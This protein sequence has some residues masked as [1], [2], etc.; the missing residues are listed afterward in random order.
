MDYGELVSI[1]YSQH[2]IIV[3]AYNIFNSCGVFREYIKFWNQH[4]SVEHTWINFKQHFCDAQK[5][6]QETN[7]LTLQETG[8]GHAN[9]VDE[10]VTC[11]VH[12][13]TYELTH[14]SISYYPFPQCL[15]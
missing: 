10:I 7:K 3:K 13:I 15:S 14:Y 8:Y 2:Q 12:E 4:P 1:P 9:L 11:T 6:L 5:E